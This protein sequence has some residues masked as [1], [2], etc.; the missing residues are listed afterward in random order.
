MNARRN[1]ECTM[2]V[3]NMEL[4]LDVCIGEVD[5]AW[6]MKLTL[7]ECEFDRFKKHITHFLYSLFIEKLQ[8]IFVQ[9]QKT[10]FGRVEI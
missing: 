1:N 9:E 6:N 4:T 10:I 8:Q 5:V 2:L 3:Y 7:D